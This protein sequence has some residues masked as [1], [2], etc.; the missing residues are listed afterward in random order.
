M[1]KNKEGK[2]TE[3]CAEIE[4]RRHITR[5]SQ[6]TQDS[7]YTHFINLM[8]RQR[9][10][11]AITGR[12]GF[13]QTSRAKLNVS[14]LREFRRRVGMAINELEAG[15]T[16]DEFEPEVAAA[17]REIG[18]ITNEIGRMAAP[19]GFLGKEGSAKTEAG[20]PHF[21]ISWNHQVV[22]KYIGRLAT[23]LR[24][25]IPEA[26]NEVIE[27][28]LDSVTGS[29]TG[30]LDEMDLSQAIDMENIDLW[31][32]EF[33][34]HRDIDIDYRRLIGVEVEPGVFVDFID[35]DAA[36]MMKRYVHSVM[37]PIA[38]ADVFGDPTM[39]KQFKQIY[40]SYAAKMRGMGDADQ[41]QI[42]KER[43]RIFKD[44][45]A[46]R[47]LVAGTYDQYQ[48]Q[49]F[50]NAMRISKALM[51]YNAMKYLGGVVFSSLADVVK[52]IF[53]WGLAK[54]LTGLSDYSQIYRSQEFMALEK[55]VRETWGAAISAF[56]SER[57]SNLMDL[58]SIEGGTWIERGIGVLAD[59]MGWVTGI[60]WWNANLKKLSMYVALK[61]VL[62]IAEKIQIAGGDIAKADIRP[63]FIT[64]L[65]AMGL[66]VDDLLKVAEQVAQHGERYEKLI[67][68]NV[69]KWTDKEMANRFSAAMVKEIDATIST[70]SVG[71][72]PLWM[73][74]FIL[75]HA[76]QFKSFAMNTMRSVIVRGMQE[77]DSRA[78]QGIL[79]SAMMGGAI[80]TLKNAEVGRE[81]TDNPKEFLLN[82][83]DR[84]GLMA[85]AMDIDSMANRL[86]RGT[87]SLQSLIGGEGSTR[88]SAKS[89]W[90]ILAGPTAGTVDDIGK[91]LSRTIP[92]AVGDKMVQ[93][94]I[95]PIFRMIPYAKTPW[96]RW[97]MERWREDWKEQL[98]VR[99]EEED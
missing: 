71:D 1:N 67:L 43:D 76:A 90:D 30:W 35:M 19:H 47:D 93:S 34:R 89:N 25:D 20:K 31:K 55:E 88:F 16:V 28:I 17:A 95:A 50:P 91:L 65:S 80:Y 52:P 73:H 58:Q 26:G 49:M 45:L 33:F 21:A 51:S 94:D 96:L 13:W 8:K 84:G 83:I 29:P 7:I 87:F 41:T 11:E 32:A 81:N 42:R 62:E 44:M 85:Y 38:L 4:K 9:D 68:P 75:Q 46:L 57:L 10:E 14:E 69:Q 70:P 37:G 39:K 63:E 27:K 92:H 5:F 23:I 22:K 56:N 99:L 72:R 98:P 82:C 15:R 60:D 6:R 77:H 66:G 54:S 97:L 3:R 36:N 48:T 12:P 59:Q 40:D 79:L 18:A 2:A 24:E 64:H 78:M 86:T 53:R 74:N 61:D